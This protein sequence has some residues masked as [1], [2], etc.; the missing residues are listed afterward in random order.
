MSLNEIES[1]VVGRLRNGERA[2]PASRLSTGADWLRFG[3]DA[4]LRAATAIRAIRQRPID[5]SVQYKPDGSP[6]T[7]IEEEIEDDIRRSLEALMPEARFVG[8]E[9]GGHWSPSGITVAIDPIDGTW[10][11]INRSETF[12]TSLAVFDSGKVMLG[13]VVNPSTGELAY[14][15]AGQGARLVQLAM[16]GEEDVAVDLPLERCTSE[17]LVNVHPARAAGPLLDCLYGAWNR[18]DVRM[19]KTIGGSPSWSL[20]EAAKGRFAYVNLWTG[21]AA[22][23]FDLAPGMALVR[24]AGGEV[25]DETNKPIDCVGHKGAFIAAVDSRVREKVVDLVAG[26]IAKNRGS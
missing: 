3:L 11:F 12:T 4:A 2:L 10:A 16:F 25:V 7:P 5:E 20:M 15:L 21:R 8:E 24:A 19:V 26:A 1:E 14:S 18:A 9:S 13:I 17:T 23:P 22:D 6:F